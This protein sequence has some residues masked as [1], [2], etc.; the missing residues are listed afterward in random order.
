[1]TVAVPSV[2]RLLASPFS[3]SS[4]PLGGRAHPNQVIATHRHLAVVL[5]P[6]AFYDS[7]PQLK[8][9]VLRSENLSEVA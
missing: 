8:R 7:K 4:D 9:R 6:Q 1:M 5:P 2:A 3:N